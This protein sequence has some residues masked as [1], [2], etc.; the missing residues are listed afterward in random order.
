[1]SLSR[2]VS[3][4][5]L[6]MKHKKLT[7]LTVSKAKQHIMDTL[8]VLIAAVKDPVMG[9]IKN[10]LEEAG[11][12]A[13]CTV[14]GAGIKTSLSNAALANG[15]LAHALDYDDS[16]W[17]LIGHPSAAVLP[18]VLALGEA[19][20]STGKDIITAYLVGTEVSCKLGLAAEPQLYEAGW[21]A[22]GVVGVLGAA[23]AS[24]YLLGLTEEQ[25]INALGIAASLAGGL[26][27]NIGSMTKPFHAGAAAQH[28]VTAALLAKH[29][30]TSSVASLD[31]EWGFFRNFTCGKREGEFPSPGEP[32]DIVDPGFFI[33]PYPSCAATHTAIDAMLSLVE[34]H[35]FTDEQVASIEVGSGPVGPVMLFHNRPQRGS[36]GKFSMPFVLAMA[37]IERKVGLDTFLDSKVNDPRVLKLMEKTRFYVAPEF[38]QRSIDE[39]P[40]I[41]KVSLKDG[42]ELIKQVEEPLGS[43]LNPMSLAQ[44]TE[45]FRDCTSRV[46]AA[47]KVER[48]LS[49]LAELETLENINLLIDQL[50]P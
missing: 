25:L 17:R 44:V 36:E 1:M 3:E 34:E 13:R 40:A 31:G 20:H 39:A 37:V 29:G 23:A 50:V 16:S 22:T 5:V 9:V 11:G 48:A 47:G 46:L 18:A 30:Y 32:F 45:K 21:H 26:R 42:R 6:A 15:I 38:A 35:D 19:G 33:K 49:M 4:F 7:E 41:V 2:K 12:D 27:Q 43:P 24:S 10:Y 14:I 8:G 28:G